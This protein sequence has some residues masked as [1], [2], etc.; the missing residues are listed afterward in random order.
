MLVSRY[1]PDKKV[2]EDQVPKIV[3]GMIS[4]GAF[5]AD[6]QDTE[7]GSLFSIGISYPEII[8]DRDSSPIITYVPI[9][10]VGNATI[11]QEGGRFHLTIPERAGIFKT[12]NRKKRDLVRRAEN[13]IIQSGA[14]KLVDIP[15]VQTGLNPIKEILFALNEM[16]KIPVKEVLSRKKNKVQMK[17]YIDMLKSLRYVDEKDGILHPGS[18]LEKFNIVGADKFHRLV[19]TDVIQKGFPFIREELNIYILNPYLELTNS[20]YLPSLLAREKVQM[21]ADDI[22]HYYINMYGTSR[23]KPKYQVAANLVEMVGVGLLRK[24][25][26]LFEADDVLFSSLTDNFGISGT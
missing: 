9:R 25:G 22:F 26:G 8:V 19:M 10:G 17:R 1:H 6:K 7:D 21:E 11:R 23:R 5:V 4:R 12:F 3:R 18:E 16:D 2:L 15:M 20:Y 14:D 24:E 13:L